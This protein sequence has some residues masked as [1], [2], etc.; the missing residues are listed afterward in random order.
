VDTFTKYDALYRGGSAFRRVLPSFLP[1]Q[2]TDTDAVYAL[3]CKEAGYRSYVGQIVRA[4]AGALFNAPYAVVPSRGNERVELDGAYAAFKEDAD[5]QGTDLTA[6]VKDRFRSALVHAASYWVAELP[7]GER[8][9]G[10]TREEWSARGLDRVRISALDA[11]SV[12]DWE[13]D[14]D[15]CYAW[16]KVHARSTTRSTPDAPVMVVDTWRVY[17]P[18]HV[19]VY[20]VSYLPNKPPKPSA[21]VPLVDSYAHGFARVP[22]LCLRLPEGMWLLDAVSDAQIEHFRLSAAYGWALRRAAYPVAI[23]HLD[24]DADKPKLGPG[25]GLVLSVT[26]KFSWA[27]PS[28]TS[29]AAMEKA[30]SVQMAEIYRMSQQ[31]S[32]SADSSAGAIGRS[33]LSKMQDAEASNAAL[34]DY[35]HVVRE[36]LEATFEFVSNALGDTGTVFAVDGLDSFNTADIAALVEAVTSAKELG[37]EDE[38]ETYRVEAHCRVAGSV[39]PADA[40]QSVK[41]AVRKEITESKP[42]PAKRVPAG[43]PPGAPNG[44]KSRTKAPTAPVGGTE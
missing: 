24:A 5:G 40:A 39:L 14:G 29:F 37:L 28:G 21:Q 31:M 35:A 6:F 10:L 19:D 34:R 30:I 38:S 32:M 13:C 3:R 41:D 23:F 33:G 42:D 9:D 22:V 36:A 26:E 17:W 16:V 20:S 4:Y 15:G 2:P 18:D 7:H 25:L 12:L 43:G 1:R 8:E 11:P 27:E 44:R